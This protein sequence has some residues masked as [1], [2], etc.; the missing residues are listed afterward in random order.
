MSAPA[1]PFYGKYAGKVENNVDPEGRGRVQVS[2]PDVLPGELCWAEAC[3]PYAGPGVGFF[4]VP[5]VKASVWVEFKGGNLNSPILA[6]AYWA[7][8]GDAPSVLPQVQ[9]WKTDGVSITL[10]SV[11]GAG[12]LTIEVGSP[13]VAVPMK[14]AC[15]AAGIELSIGGT[16]SVK[17]TGASVSINGDGLVVT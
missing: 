10:S 11:P 12:G 1:G 4:A 5:P 17:L 8:T 3:V 2:V 6:G 9:V 15:T 13:T 7:G 14:F 16:A